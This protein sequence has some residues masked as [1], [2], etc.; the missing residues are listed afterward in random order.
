[1]KTGKPK[2]A[3]G[4]AKGWRSPPV[5]V[6]VVD[7]GRFEF[8]VEEAGTFFFIRETPEERDE[9]LEHAATDARDA[10]AVARAN[11]EP[12]SCQ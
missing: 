11:A 5:R 8:E 6:V 12:S 3:N 1:M 9:Q 4:G 10:W 7:V 2:L